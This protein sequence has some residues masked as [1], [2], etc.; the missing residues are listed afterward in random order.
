MKCKISFLTFFFFLIFQF[1]FSQTPSGYILKPDRVF[2]GEKIHNDW[3]V[4]VKENKIIACGN[5]KQVSVK[6]F[7][8]FQIKNLKG[9]TLLPGLIEGHSHL[10]LHPYNETAGDFPL[11]WETIANAKPLDTTHLLPFEGMGRVKP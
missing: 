5:E 6:N 4:I 9:Q 10:L 11:L 3:I 1:G 2:D 7:S 8:D